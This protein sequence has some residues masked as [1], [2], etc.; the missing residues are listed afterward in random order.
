MSGSL[1]GNLPVAK[2]VCTNSAFQNWENNDGMSS[3]MSGSWN[4]AQTPLIIWAL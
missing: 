3:V 1:G 4:W 2:C